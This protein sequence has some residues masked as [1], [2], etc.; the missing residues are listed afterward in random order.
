MPGAIVMAGLSPVSGMLFDKF[1]P[2]WMCISGCL[3]LTFGSAMFGFV[4][5]NTSQFY[6]CFAYALR[7][8]G[9]SLVNMPTNTWSLNALR[10]KSIA[11]GNAII[12]TSRQIFGSIGTAV[13]VTVMMLVS[14]FYAAS[15][16]VVATARGIN[17]A[18]FGSTVITIAALILTI[19]KVGKDNKSEL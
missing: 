15:G 8:A 19:A 9:I 16:D 10:D 6:V 13:L 5:P 1:G 14:N 18:F 17:A 7:M 4:T 3:I 2:R 11:H 12:N